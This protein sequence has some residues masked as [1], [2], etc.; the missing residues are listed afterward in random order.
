MKYIFISHATCDKNAVEQLANFI[1]KSSSGQIKVWYSSDSGTDGGFSAGDEWRNRIIKNII[2]SDEVIAFITPNSNDQPWIMYE[3]G[4]A[5]GTSKEKLI[6]LRFQIDV[7]EVSSPIRHKQ[8]FSYD[9]AKSAGVFLSKLFDILGLKYD[10]ETYKTSLQS[11]IEKMKVAFTQKND[12]DDSKDKKVELNKNHEEIENER[13]SFVE[14]SITK[15]VENIILMPETDI[16][17]WTSLTHY[18]EV[19]YWQK[20]LCEEINI[21]NSNGRSL[22]SQVKESV[23][24]YSEIREM[25]LCIKECGAYLKIRAYHYSVTDNVHF[26]ECFKQYAKNH[27]YEIQ[28]MGWVGNAI[29]TIDIMEDAFK[30]CNESKADFVNGIFEVEQNGIAWMEDEINKISVSYNLYKNAEMEKI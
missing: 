3:C 1:Q 7:N 6:P 22:I 24:R 13:T 14:R 5:E 16:N 21:M 9:D 10:K 27:H 29:K 30:S 17:E 12:K 26:I 23:N 4:Y 18:E 20:R 15:L 11:S 2:E 8:I 19:R 28:E 25:F